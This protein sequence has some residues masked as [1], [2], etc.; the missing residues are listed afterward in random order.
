MYGYPIISVIDGV[1]SNTTVS[2]RATQKSDVVWR[3]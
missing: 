2:Y 1:K 3:L